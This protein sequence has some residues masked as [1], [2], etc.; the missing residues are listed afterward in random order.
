MQPSRHKHWISSQA[1]CS[2]ASEAALGELLRSRMAANDA[3]VINVRY[4][5]ARFPMRICAPEV[6]LEIGPAAW[7]PHEPAL[8]ELL[9]SRQ[10]RRCSRSWFP[11]HQSPS[12][13][14][15]PSGKSDHPASPR[16]DRPAGNPQPAHYS[17]YY[18]LARMAASPVRTA[19]SRTAIVGRGGCLQATLLPALGR[20]TSWRCKAACGWC[21]HR[22]ADSGREDYA[23][24][25]RMIFGRVPTFAISCRHCLASNAE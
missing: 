18:D 11:V 5:D 3:H 20:A 12:V 24:M 2:A 19:A 23:A 10:F 21:R 8:G 7:L 22:S 1:S 9:R 15:E 6:R 14:S 16:H 13:R 17:R 4:Q 25:Q